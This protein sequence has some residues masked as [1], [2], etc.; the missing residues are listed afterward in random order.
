MYDHTLANHKIRHKATLKVGGQ[1]GEI[2]QMATYMQSS[3]GFCIFS[4][5]IAGEALM[6]FFCK[7][8]IMKCFFF[9]LA[10]LF[11]GALTDW[12]QE[13]CRHHISASAFLHSLIQL[14]I[15]FI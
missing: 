13:I 10:V 6:R 1:P 4:Q 3:S 2:L 14:M 8:A 15:Y 7:I 12:R 11:V 9:I 5:V